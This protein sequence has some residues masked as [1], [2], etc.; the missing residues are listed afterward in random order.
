MAQQG[1]NRRTRP[2]AGESRASMQSSQSTANDVSTTGAGERP[3]RVESAGGGGN[4]GARSAERLRERERERQRRRITTG[5]IIAVAA[6]AIFGILFILVNLPQE[7]PV[8]AES[9]ARYEGIEMLRTQEG[10]PLLGA[11]DAPVKVAEYSSFDCPHC[12]DFHAQVIGDLVERVRAG[13]ISLTYIPMYG[14]GSIANGQGAAV[15]AICAAEQRKFWEFHD[16]M[17]DWQGRFGNQSFT[18]NRLNAGMDALGLDRGQMGAC[19]SSG[20]VQDILNTART[21][22]LALTNYNGTPTITINGVVPVNSD[23]VPL[24]DPAEI[25]AAID[26]EIERIGAGG[27]PEATTEATAEVGAEATPEAETTSEAV[28]PIEPEATPESTSEA[29]PEATTEAG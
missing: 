29:T 16:M 20:S 14:T 21:Q 26:R 28:V 11:L 5:V 9:A 8:P 12:R 25:L 6:A 23:Q 18:N 4:S 27:R 15:A 17:F 10:Y 13:D 22:S 2:K 3:S 7:A 24:S 19:I 1:R